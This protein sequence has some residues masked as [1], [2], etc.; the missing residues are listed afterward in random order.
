MERRLV[1]GWLGT[2][3]ASVLGPAYAQRTA[4]LPV[5][6]VLSNTVP[7]ESQSYQLMLSALR[8]LGHIEHRT[9]QVEIR[10]AQGR[11]EAYPVLAKELA[12]LKV[13]A[14]QA[15]SPVGVRAAKLATSTIPIV[16]LD[17]ES[18]PVR[19]GWARTFAQPGGNLSGLFLDHPAMAG[20]WLQLL[21]EAMGHRANIG[22]LWDSNTGKAQLDAVK[23]A[24]RMLSVAVTIIEFK[25]IDALPAALEEAAAKASALLLLSSP[26]I[27]RRASQIA[28][29]ALVHRLPMI[30]PFRNVTEAGGLISYGPNIQDFYPRLAIFVDKIFKGHVIGEIPIEQPTSFELS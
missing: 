26:T 24:A 3:L 10:S 6:G 20:K 21:T 17:L 29:F 27:P 22:V 30:S 18:D 12:L 25:S 23:A 14:I 16:A 19:E 13:D 4:R 9:F 1:S 2:A 28:S 11:V 7:A 8:K 5:L 15:V